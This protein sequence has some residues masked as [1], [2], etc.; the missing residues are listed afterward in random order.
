MRRSLLGAVV[1][2]TMIAAASAQ[3][4]PP[5]GPPVSL[6]QAKRV[7]AAAEREAETHNWQQV[8]AIVDSGGH[9]IML[10]SL[11]GAQHGSIAIA[12][13]KAESAVD[14]KRS[15]K[16]F[17]DLLGAGGV[18][19]RVLGS[20]NIVPID[21]GLPLIADGR[22]VGDIGVSG[23]LP[24]QDAQVAKAGADGCCGSR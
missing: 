1:I 19:L 16:V 15:T 21:G 8:I 6:A 20:S 24:A 12:Q 2:V 4:L 14:F 23:M 9:L 18:N 7:L 13:K 11:D 5:Y 17:E 3:V 10:Q 22:I